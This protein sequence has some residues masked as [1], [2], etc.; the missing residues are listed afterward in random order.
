MNH[1][2]RPDWKDAPA[3]ANWL[4]CGY[5][6]SWVW[7][8]DEPIFEEQDGGEWMWWSPGMSMDAIETDLG[9]E[10]RPRDGWQFLDKD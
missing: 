8:S 1:Q 4:T 5:S 7:H 6:G 9:K 10:K 3:W 2:I